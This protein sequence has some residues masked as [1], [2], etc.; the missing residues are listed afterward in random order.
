MALP[1]TT[2]TGRTLVY[3]GLA[4]NDFDM[5][6]HRL[7]NLDTSN[8]PPIG[9]PPTIHPPDNQWLHDWDAVTHT[10]IATQPHFS[11]IF[12]ILTRAQQD[13]ITA[14]GTIR[15]GVWAATPLTPERVPTLDAIRAPLGNVSMAGKRLVNL[16]N[17]D[18]PGDAVN[19]EF[20]DFM[21]QGLQPKQAVKCATTSRTPIT[22]LYELDGVQLEDGDRV[23]VKD[24]VDSAG[25]GYVNGIYIAQDGPWV[26]S[27]DCDEKEEIERAYVTVLE[28]EMNA[29]TSWVQVN[30]IEHSPP[31]TLDPVKWILFSTP[32]ASVG[33]VAGAGLSADG[34][35]LNVG[36]TPDRIV[37]GPDNVDIDP[38]YI[39][40]ESITTVGTITSGSWH[41]D[42]VSPQFGGTGVNNS[43]TITI[44]GDFSTFVPLEFPD[45]GFNRTLAFGLTAN[46]HLTLP[47]AGTVAT[48]NGVETFTNKRINRRVA[49]IASNSKPAINVD[50]TD[51]FRI[52]ALAEAITSMTD[53][54]TGTPANRQQLEIW[55]K[56]SS[57]AAGPGYAIAWGS[58]WR[59]SP[60]L[61]LPTLAIE[62]KNIF[63]AFVYASEFSNWV[64]TQKVS[65]IP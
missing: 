61:P 13:S 11:H 5:A 50:T 56:Q 6:H 9:I 27:P 33:L 48:I 47:T 32:Q 35:T 49:T 1:P 19:L 58:A 53:Q 8:L 38:G 18:D 54:L 30:P 26:R 17:P 63:L 60:E 20:M 59:A 64:L 62:G 51:V 52:T 4:Q 55:I 41:G 42:L 31:T 36:G 45:V 34:N 2:D 28:G 29:G 21:L 46:T 12:G 16:A 23:L 10:W 37:V 44:A 40:Q 24:W 22:D 14:L 7:L 15:S 43:H 65:D 57:G 39:G 25:E 3:D